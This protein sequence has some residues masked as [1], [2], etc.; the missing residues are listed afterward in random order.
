VI[1]DDALERLRFLAR[2]VQ[3]E[4]MHLEQTDRRL[5]AEPFTVERARRLDSDA[6]LAERVEAFVARLGRLQDTIGD[7]LVP[8]LLLALGEPRGAAVD[9]LDRAER[10][11]W[12]S[13]ADAWLA[14]R[15]LRNQMIHEYI[16]DP[17]VL[18]DALQAGHGH[19]PLLV[20]AA[21]RLLSELRRRGWSPDTAA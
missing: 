20:D 18:S 13:S 8:A 12:L 14:V 10:F 15:K 21:E 4:R 1:A 19:V 16:E 11:G 6:L 17:L 3:R 5:F 9:N 7:K 2:V